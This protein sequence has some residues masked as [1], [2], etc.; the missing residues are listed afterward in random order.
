[1]IEHLRGTFLA[2]PDD[3]YVHRALKLLAEMLGKNGSQPTQRLHEVTTRI[4]KSVALS[5]VSRRNASGNVR[6]PGGQ[7]NSWEDTAHAVL[8]TTQA[9]RI[10]QCTP[11]NVRDLA[12]RQV[13]P[14][15]RSGGR[16]VYPAEAVQR[17]AAER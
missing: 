7:G 13:L 3:D 15:R 12:R 11:A 16:W 9:A 8:N 4:G 5:D 17:R 10:L 2:H 6:I 14:A 1:M